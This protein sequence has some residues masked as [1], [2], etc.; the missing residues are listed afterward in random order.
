VADTG[1]RLGYLIL[2]LAIVA[3]VVGAV[4]GFTG[5]VVQLVI[6]GLTVSSLLLAPAIVLGYAVRAA[7]RED[8]EGTVR[9]DAGPAD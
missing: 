4:R 2:L 9:E 6:A 8:R 7:D 1:K 3:F 5:V